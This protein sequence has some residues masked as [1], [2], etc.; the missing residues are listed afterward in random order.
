[1]GNLFSRSS[2]PKKSQT[3]EGSEADKNMKTTAEH[4]VA[5]LN[6]SEKEKNQLSVIGVDLVSK[7]CK[8]EYGTV[9]KGKYNHRAVKF[10]EDGSEIKPEKEFNAVKMI[11]VQKLQSSSIRIREFDERRENELLTSLKHPYVV[12][13]FTIVFA[14]AKAEE[15][16][17]TEKKSSAFN[18]ITNI[19]TSATVKNVGPA[20]STPLEK[21][22]SRIY[23]VF[24][25]AE[26]GSLKAFLESLSDKSSKVEEKVAKMWILG[27]IDGL[28]YLHSQSIISC[29]ISLRTILLFQYKNDVR[30]K[31]NPFNYLRFVELAETEVERYI[32]EDLRLLA[33]VME[34]VK[35]YF[36]F[37]P[38]TQTTFENSIKMMKNENK[39][40]KSIKDSLEQEFSDNFS[41]T[42]G[43]SE[44]ITVAKKDDLDN[45]KS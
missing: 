17:V 30:P 13:V 10:K 25:F 6:I 24:E 34:Q 43:N 41:K 23:L 37:K 7:I 11:D 35:Q 21:E 39:D 16:D 33:E 1:M 31:L 2:S 19:M 3:P 14:K 22:I 27:L 12:S 44:E 8:C 28:R 15:S 5:N 40:A 45:N 29:N 20:S 42:D 9:Y 4:A 18:F 26:F 32:K 36:D 38:E